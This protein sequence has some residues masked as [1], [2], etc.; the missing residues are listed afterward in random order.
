MI[1]G[2]R[3]RSGDYGLSTE[4]ECRS[5]HERLPTRFATVSARLGVVAS[6]SQPSRSQPAA[7]CRR[8]PEPIGNTLPM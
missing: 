3:M 5:R 2:T 1:I 6:F 4:C 8:S 7:K